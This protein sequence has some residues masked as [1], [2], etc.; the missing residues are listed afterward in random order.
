MESNPLNLQEP[1]VAGTY[2]GNPHGYPYRILRTLA[3]DAFGIIY[4]ASDQFEK[5]YAIRIYQPCDFSG[6]LDEMKAFWNK[7][8]VRLRSLFHPSLAYLHDIFE[9][10]GSFYLVSEL[11][12][13]PLSFYVS[14]PPALD[15]NQVLAIA[16]DL[17]FGLSFIHWHELVHGP[18]SV[19]TVYLD[20]EGHSAKIADFGIHPH[21]KPAFA[22]EAHD[23]PESKPHLTSLGYTPVQ[24]DL[25]QIGIL[26][27]SL[28]TGRA[29]FFLGLSVEGAE[30]LCLGSYLQRS[31]E[32]IP[33]AIGGL[34]AQLLAPP[35]SYRY[36]TAID[37]WL[38]F[39]NLLKKRLFVPPE[40]LT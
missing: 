26:L 5:L 7:E 28:M 40:S 39:R 1:S 15:E 33:F 35:S 24:A 38:D 37:A 8:A 32:K 6:S 2:L 16:R 14:T 17:F 9:S 12:G 4:L 30:N 10:Q 21:F 19:D 11:L 29:S 34:I 31:A 22:N 36:Q 18:L 3:S 23:L 20:R 25:Y 27:L 13:R